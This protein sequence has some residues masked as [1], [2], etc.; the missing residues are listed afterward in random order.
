MTDLTADEATIR[1][2]VDELHIDVPVYGGRVVGD[3]LELQLYGGAVAYW[4][5]EPTTTESA[6][7]AGDLSDLLKDEL[8]EIARIH[9]VE[10]W[11]QMLKA[12]LVAT[13]EGLR[14]GS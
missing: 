5:Q 7:P 3:R 9:G 8:K 6:I 4:P 14:E 11:N 12:D 13:L 2:A 1:R 10:K